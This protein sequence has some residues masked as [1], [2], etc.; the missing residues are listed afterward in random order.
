MDFHTSVCYPANLAAVQRLFQSEEFFKA[1]AAGSPASVESVHVE[2]L[3]SEIRVTTKARIDA[4]VI[5]LPPVAQ[6]FIPSSGIEITITETWNTTDNTGVI[7][8]HA[9]SLPV[10]MSA[11]CAFIEEEE[12]VRRDVNGKLK[13]NV[14]IIGRKLEQKAVAEVSKIAEHEQEIASQYLV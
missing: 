14:P 3:I 1:R 2:A 13:V 11:T 8:V 7:Q 5:D 9:D 12:A 4:A 10:S 6:R